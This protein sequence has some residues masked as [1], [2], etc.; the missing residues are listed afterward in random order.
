M[1]RVFY[2]VY[3]ELGNGFLESVYHSALDLALRESGIQVASQVAIPVYFRGRTVGDFRADLIVNEAVLLE[4]KAIQSLDRTH[5]S[6]VLNYL[7]ATPLEVA[8]LLNFGP[9]PEF[10][11]FVLDNRRKNI[12]VHPRQSVAGASQEVM[13]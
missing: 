13:G 7:Y 2:E 10:K 1:L 3:N 11:R 6:Q 5:E 9:K 12:R 4:L 8:L